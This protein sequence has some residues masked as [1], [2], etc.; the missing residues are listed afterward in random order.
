MR[1]AGTH[2]RPT[3]SRLPTSAGLARPHARCAAERGTAS[4]RDTR[5]GLTAASRRRP[6]RAASVPVARSASLRGPATP[7]PHCER[8]RRR[9][10]CARWTSTRPPLLERPDAGAAI[11]GCSS[12]RLRCRVRLSRPVLRRRSHCR[13][14]TARASP[15]ASSVST[16][17]ASRTLIYIPTRP[18]RLRSRH[19]PCCGA[20][21]N[22]R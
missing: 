22:A 17:R 13:R 8:R 16:G 10:R 19:A 14:L 7:L 1:S 20:P 18:P 4:A 2:W 3:G 11:V 15:D 5:R 21:I 6:A 12:E 9:P